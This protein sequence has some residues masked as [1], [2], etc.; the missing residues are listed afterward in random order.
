[1][2]SLVVAPRAGAWIE[3]TP[4][5]MIYWSVTSLPVRERG[6]KL[7]EASASRQ[8]ADVAPRAGAWIEAMSFVLNSMPMPSLPVRERGLKQCFVPVCCS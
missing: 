2:L 7:A 4:M 3:A 1:M 8:S 6:L 5:L